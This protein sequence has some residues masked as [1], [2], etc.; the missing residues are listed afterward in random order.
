MRPYTCALRRQSFYKFWWSPELNLPK[1]NSIRSH[2]IW[3][4]AGK[5]HC[6]SVANQCRKDKLAYKHAIRVEQQRKKIC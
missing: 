6:G 1:D 5:P 2:K 4:T 3:L